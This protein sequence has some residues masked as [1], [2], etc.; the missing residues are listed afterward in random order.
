MNLRGPN[1]RFW[2]LTALLL[3]VRSAHSEPLCVQIPGSANTT[4]YWSVGWLHDGSLIAGTNRL[5]EFANGDLRTEPTPWSDAVR[6]F[7]P[8][9]STQ[10]LAA[11]VGG[12]IRFDRRT[13][14]WRGDPMPV[15]QK[16]AGEFV[17]ARLSDDGL[18]VVLSTVTGLQYVNGNAVSEW[19]IPTSTRIYLSRVSGRL[20]VCHYPYAV[21]GV[22]S[23]G[24]VERPDL[25]WA[26]GALMLMSA[27]GRI[28]G[29]LEGSIGVY[30]PDGTFLWAPAEAEK[31]RVEW[32]VAAGGDD[33]VLWIATHKGGIRWYDS[34]TGNKIAEALV[35]RQLSGRVFAVVQHSDGRLA[36]ATE[37]R[38]YVVYPPAV[39]S[40]L[41]P[42]GRLLFFQ[43]CGGGAV[44]ATSGGCV[45]VGFGVPT[46]DDTALALVEWQGKVVVGSIGRIYVDGKPCE[47]GGTGSAE[48]IPAGDRLL[49]LQAN[50]ALLLDRD[51]KVSAQVALPETP[52]GAAEVDGAFLIGTSSGSVM[53]WRPSE[54]LT[55]VQPANPHHRPV[56]IKAAGG[57]VWQLSEQDARRDTRLVPLPGGIGPVDVFGNSSGTWLLCSDA[58]GGASLWSVP[59]DGPPIL[60]DVPG[61]LALRQPQGFLVLPSGQFAIADSS[62][63]IVIERDAT[64]PQA[65]PVPGLS[66][67]VTIDPSGERV[68]SL[69][70]PELKLAAAEDTLILR[71][72]G[73]D[74]LAAR[75]IRWRILPDGKWQQGGSFG[76]EASRLPSGAGAVAVDLQ[77]GGQVK[78]DV[79]SYFRQYPW[80]LRTWSLSLYVVSLI[81][82]VLLAVRLRT[83]RLARH[84]REL[85]Q[86]VA[87]RT[88]ALARA[89]AAKEEF[90][91]SMSHEI[92]NPLNG[93]LGICSMLDEA[94]L[95]PREQ[96]LARTL[97]GCSEQLRSLLDDILDFSSIERGDIPLH[98][99]DFVLQSAIEAAVHT[100]DV[101]G[102]RTE[103]NQ[104]LEPLWF[105]GDHLKLRQIVINLVTNALKYGVP[106]RAVI[107]CEVEG[108]DDSPDTSI[109]TVAVRNTGP[110]IPPDEISSLFEA[111]YR[112]SA[113]RASRSPGVGLGL[114]VSRRIALAM[115]GDLTA[116][117]EDGVTE[118]TLRVPLRIAS[119]PRPLLHPKNSRPPMTVSRALAVEDEPYNRLVLGHT[120]GQL[121]YSVDWATDGKTAIAM[122]LE[123]HYDL[124]FT[125]WELPDIPGP[126]VARR[127]LASL[128]DPKPP[129]IA[130][131]AYATRDRIRACL[132]AGIIDVVTKPVTKEK[133]ES[134]IKG[135]GSTLRAK[136]SLDITRSV[137]DVTPLQRF[138]DPA[139]VIAEFR[140]TFLQRWQRVVFALD[141][142]EATAAFEIHTL[143]GQALVVSATALAEQLELL[144]NAA[145]EQRWDDAGRLRTCVEHELTL[146]ADALDHFGLKRPLAR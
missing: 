53:R 54:S 128:A 37:S 24:P 87:E 5:V 35:G 39:D 47:I 18:S 116:R 26:K 85:E 114:A 41:L 50:R 106:S 13:G 70:A 141:V 104:P 57:A 80:Y 63:V 82:L 10:L 95:A 133:L 56:R 43:L 115:L 59:P 25:A 8:L 105:S 93:V 126:E 11:G 55:M 9:G 122:A 121:G 46:L 143:R 62:R 107:T 4:P 51:L 40:L 21:L 36:V 137:C 145:R 89:S 44:A 61:I 123:G 127:I 78:T 38:V 69:G 130:V 97:R 1:V 15:A 131:T 52:V 20:A 134:V 135:L 58:G 112:G 83:R 30:R 140:S 120:F 101:G 71:W 17:D 72:S 34:A 117:S 144:E 7:V 111:F 91:A 125:D 33:R 86:L 74:P 48:L 49:V 136:Q 138:G 73:G 108:R 29:L 118:F 76:L 98:P 65:A 22:T 77:S 79:V 124:I 90:L 109:L 23:Q 64:R 96:L 14:V 45:S 66:A 100:V 32:V 6:A 103:I 92:R 88:Q 60:L 119:S 27:G 12:V 139:T 99:E 81:A 94:P 142:Q 146:V 113:A 28:V 129:I 84:A 16:P 31:M 3:I 110:T 2:C 67:A 102:A 19:A 68:L 132:D 42:S 75:Q